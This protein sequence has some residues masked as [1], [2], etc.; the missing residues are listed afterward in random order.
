MRK[1]LAFVLCFAVGKI[2]AQLPETEIF[3][4]DIE[5]KNKLIKVEK[6]ININNRKGY[7]NQ[8]FFLADGKTVLFSASDS[9]GRIHICKY[10]IRS[11]ETKIHTRTKTS[12]YSPMLAP[13][14]VYISSVVVEE[15]SAQRVWMYD[16]KK[17]EVKH[18][19]T[20]STDSIGYYAWLGKDSI[21][22]YKLTDP[23][24]LRV[25]N[26][27]TGEDN[28]LCDHPARSFKRVNNSTF[29]YVIHEE[30]QNLIH[31][32]DTRVKKATLFATDKP[33]N[34]D[35]VWQADLGMVK[36]EGSKLLHYSVETKVWVEVADLSSFGIKKITRFTF[37]T[38]KKRLA[39]V[40]NIE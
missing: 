16:L 15:D 11:K 28:W 9:M 10:N 22:Y 21:L 19:L 8:P 7:D 17:P 37:S 23:H 34:Q 36:S 31:F 25:L 38:D 32:Y 4:A 14:G 27:K 13:D 40:S 33:E 39:V 29:F 20:E 18:C 5:I 2:F 12:E 30:K 26:L 24:S 1:N 3:L 35:Y 6:A